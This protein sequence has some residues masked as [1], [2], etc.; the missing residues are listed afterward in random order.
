MPESPN[1]HPKPSTP[2]PSPFNNEVSIPK[3]Q[4]DAIGNPIAPVDLTPK[5]SQKCNAIK[6]HIKSQLTYSYL[7][8]HA[9][10]KHSIVEPAN[11]R[12]W[13]T[14]EL[15]HWLQIG[16]L[17]EQTKQK[18]KLYCAGLSSDTERLISHFLRFPLI[19]PFR[20]MWNTTTT[21]KDL[22]NFFANEAYITKLKRS[23]KFWKNI[24]IKTTQ[25]TRKP[26][27]KLRTLPDKLLPHLLLNVAQ[28]TMYC[29]SAN[30]KQL[31]KC[32]ALTMNALGYNPDYSKH[33]LQLLENKLETL[34]ALASNL[35]STVHSQ[36]KW[37]SYKR[38]ALVNKIITA[39][40][41]GKNIDTLRKRLT[42][43]TSIPK[44]SKKQSKPSS[45]NIVCSMIN[46]GGIG[47]VSQ[48]SLTELIIIAEQQGT[49]M[50]G[51]VETLQQPNTTLVPFD[52]WT[53]FQAPCETT[54]SKPR[55]G[56][57]LFVR[58]YLNPTLLTSTSP[59]TIGQHW[60]WIKLRPS[61][62]TEEFYMCLLYWSP[63][64]SIEIDHK[65][66]IKQFKEYNTQGD[67]FMMGDFNGGESY[68]TRKKL[69]NQLVSE[70]G[71]QTANTLQHSTHL[72]RSSATIIDHILG[73]KK[74]NSPAFISSSFKTKQIR[75]NSGHKMITATLKN[76]KPTIQ[77]Y[78]NYHF[79]D[80]QILET[81]Q[82]FQQELQTRKVELTK[83]PTQQATTFVDVFTA[84]ITET[85]DKLCRPYTTTN[86]TTNKCN[87][88]WWNSSLQHLLVT[89][90]STA[91]RIHK[92]QKQKSKAKKHKPELIKLQHVFNKLNKLFKKEIKMARKWNKP[93]YTY[94][95]LDSYGYINQRIW[96]LLQRK[97][98]GN[99]IGTIYNQKEFK[100]F[101]EQIWK[102][103]PSTIN[104]EE[105]EKLKQHLNSRNNE[106]WGE[107]AHQ[108][109]DIH[110]QISKE[111]VRNARRELPNRKAAGTDKI[112][113]E[114]LKHLPE[115]Y[116]ELLATFFNTC[117]RSKL[118]GELT[119]GAVQFIPKP[120]K[121]QN[122]PGNWRPIALLSCLRKL[123]EK[124]LTKRL[125][126][127]SES[128]GIL[129]EQQAGFREARNCAQQAFIL[130]TLITKARNE[131]QHLVAT[132]LDVSKAF[133]SISHAVLLNKCIQIGLP[134][135]FVSALKV[136]LT[137]LKF[138]IKNFGERS[139]Q[140]NS[141]NC[142]FNIER[143]CPQGGIL[144]PLFYL[145]YVH[146][147]SE[148][149]E[150]QTLGPELYNKKTG[151]LMFADDTTLITTGKNIKATL[152][153]A[154][155]QL[156][157]CEKWANK[158]QITFNVEK[159]N[160]M[161]FKP[162]AY[163]PKL[164]ALKLYGKQIP[165]TSKF[166][167]LGI[168][169]CTTEVN[170]PLD[171]ITKAEER[172]EKTKSH[173]LAR[174][175][176]G[177]CPRAARDI[178]SMTILTSML[179][180]CEITP[181]CGQNLTNAEKIHRRAAR[182]ILGVPYTQISEWLTYEE[183]G[184]MRISSTINQRLLNF[185]GSIKIGHAILP[186][187]A[188]KYCSENH[189]DYGNQ[190]DSLIELY[191]LNEAWTDITLQE[192][193]LS[194]SHFLENRIHKEKT[195]N[196]WEKTV[197]NN[198]ATM[199]YDWWKQKNSNSPNGETLNSEHFGKIGKAQPYIRTG[200][201]NACYGFIWRRGFIGPRNQPTADCYFCQEPN[202]DTPYHLI[203]ECK[204]KIPQQHQQMIRQILPNKQY[205]TDIELGLGTNSKGISL[206]VDTIVSILDTFFQL[207][208]IR[209]RLRDPSAEADDQVY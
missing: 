29:Y 185:V 58:P 76:A 197:H 171:R 188:L 103:P 38:Q 138:Y 186:K 139:K 132:F 202:K 99:T 167:Y 73:R 86:G 205:Y 7:K 3:L 60:I 43:L 176:G 81:E 56:L 113:N 47:R 85:Q 93:T 94:P 137:D 127:W 120:N 168:P 100:N 115:D 145:L 42:L 119:I 192:D 37:Y 122:Q 142:A 121:D 187:L 109:S 32:W 27:Q 44:A 148:N 68:G 26:D 19:C 84:I 62:P 107:G 46:A 12:R 31:R 134:I 133:D 191:N 25:S 39:I 101:W 200:S 110:C 170:K 160:T 155:K 199:E 135:P 157:I 183:L 206:P 180:G 102:Q 22:F 98:E 13:V 123:L 144:S 70:L 194:S 97:R 204:H 92:L 147:L 16:L 104:K 87:K 131:K 15:N 49:D 151:I 105:E 63:T 195:Q 78:K 23:F 75:T 158:N 178:Y 143:G 152:E 1:R 5:Q 166:I 64:P 30:I 95:E 28:D 88:S 52:G 125:C 149:Q 184:W 177:V 161:H 90:R 89:K 2:K 20:I 83:I 72:T 196:N 66:L 172:F 17:K 33:T 153:A 117:L 8:S 35:S 154:Q 10:N 124:I 14:G 209:C 34:K 190:V 175:R 162:T 181:I 61:P 207:Y 129:G 116:D 48:T 18:T 21:N 80:L 165:W 128:K 74:D 54:T 65:E 59:L 173:L 198:I 53:T 57:A 182:L 36:N 69:F 141:P 4:Y 156:T 67:A 118:P 55:A 96:N 111:E 179:Y 136:L 45:R 150:I 193:I 159:S 174:N 169:I 208:R 163:Q 82:K 126:H 50:L 51:V 41:C 114:S 91:V 201:I 164:T 77:K 203:H 40:Y 106:K 146:D 112:S 140:A 11:I 24:C 130:K 189:T 79:E 71:L 108:P 9:S 6:T